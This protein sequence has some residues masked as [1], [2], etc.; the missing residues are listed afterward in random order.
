MIAYIQL[1]DT[2]GEVFA[3][4]S[5][6]LLKLAETKNSCEIIIWSHFL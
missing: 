3:K 6:P 5:L 4:F 1:G 2:P